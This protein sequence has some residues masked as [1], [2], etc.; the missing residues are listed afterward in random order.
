MKARKE[1]NVGF[2][3]PRNTDI[4]A[5][6]KKRKNENDIQK[7]ISSDQVPDPYFKLG[8]HPDIVQRVWD[9]VT[10]KI[11]EDCKWIVY[12][13][14]VLVTPK[15]GIIFGFTCGTSYVLR[16]SP[17][18]IQEVVNK[19]LKTEHKFMNNYT[20]DLSVIG[21]DWFFGEFYDE[22]K[23]WCVKTFEYFNK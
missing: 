4:L 10:D 6:L 12:G 16:F 3:D 2:D 18:V 20:L 17:N 14:P 7:S 15:S 8:S 11:S 23:E 13:N 9:E 22:E 5:Y 1:M 19:G 21:K